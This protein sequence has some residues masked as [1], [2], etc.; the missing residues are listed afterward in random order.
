MAHESFEDD[1]TA[2]IMNEHFIN[3]KVDREERPDIDALYM[4]AVVAMTGQG[5]WPMSVFMSPEGKPF[6][7]G[8]YFP[9]VPRFNM[10]SFKDLLLQ[11]ERLWRED[12]Q[13]LL[14]KGDQLTDHINNTPT[15]TPAA[16]LIDKGIFSTAAD[17]I[18]KRF[19]WTNGGWGSPPKFPQ[20]PVIEF[21]FRQYDRNK[22]KLAI[23]MATKTLH[24]MAKGGM[25]DIIGGGFHRYSV[26]TFWL[27][28]HFEK[29]LYDN[30]LLIETYLHGWQITE[31]DSFRDVAVQSLEFINREL[32]DVNGG[33]YSSLDADSEGEEGTYY[34]WSQDEITD[35]VGDDNLSELVTE[36]YGITST[37]NFE[38][39]NIPTWTVRN[40]EMAEK[41]GV[42]EEIISGDIGK[43]T[44]KLL[45]YR[46]QRVRPGLDDKILTSWNG[47]ALKALST[48]ARVLL[49]D[50]FLQD[51]QKLAGFLLDEMVVNDKL[52]RSWRNGKANFIA[53]LEDHAALGLGLLELYQVDFD[54]RWYQA[55]VNQAEEILENF[56]DPRGGFFDTRHDHEQLIARP[57]G[58]QDSPIPSG[59]SMAVVLL[60]KM[61]ALTG[62]GRFSDPA[63][64]S[65]RAMQ[66]NAAKYP[67]A[68]GNWLCAA[69]FA[70]GPQLQLAIM[71]SGQD[72]EFKD[73]TAV[74]N[75]G[76]LPRLV[77][78]SAPPGSD[79]DLSLLKDREQIDGKTT[80]Y[81]CQGFTCKLPTTSPEELRGQIEETR[82]R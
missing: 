4:D 45:E 52:M 62:E 18:F 72:S 74:V 58:L 20:S 51:A 69:D 38:G 23:D 32:R 41:R 3:I 24:A 76:Y 27:V 31:D 70:L 75:Q 50:K 60:L 5:G 11:I 82:N 12:R 9:P 71:G 59:N 77:M 40:N 7:G 56:Q 17:V 80:A 15:L 46:S 42:S 30:A 25:Y 28:P 6:Y 37:G 16:D 48:A 64:A 29:M 68:F 39:K 66:G 34:V 49:E 79:I 22:D 53:Y 47:L 44:R 35:A 63:E 61:A 54:D 33:Y 36:A 21:L 26:D 8:T 55:S 43:A 1:E 57:K 2:A 65:I 13:E 14:T 19:D 78:A 73:L 81:L 10:P 67:S